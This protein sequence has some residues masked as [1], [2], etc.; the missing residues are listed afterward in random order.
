MSLAYFGGKSGSGTYQT[1]I[2]EIPPHKT[3]VELFGGMLGIYR[4]KRPAF[5]NLVI[6]KNDELIDTYVEKFGFEQKWELKDI[7]K[8]LECMLW[9]EKH[10]FQG[11]TLDLL[12]STNLYRFL[13]NNEV[14]IYA[15]PPYPHETRS[16]DTRYKHEL[17]DEEH[18]ELLR[19]LHGLQ[20]AKIAISTYPNDIYYE[21]FYGRDNWRFIEFESQTRHGKAIEQLWMNYPEPTELHDYRYLGKDYRERERISRKLKRW[22]ANFRDLAPLEQAAMIQRLITVQ[23]PI[24]EVSEG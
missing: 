15:D 3:Y 16:S 22:E 12:D 8:R 11:C 10:C 4:H 24:A 14:F 2:N 1:I 17:T 23:D 21:Y 19:T 13:D 9:E 5:Y 18:L 6:E 7:F 20:N